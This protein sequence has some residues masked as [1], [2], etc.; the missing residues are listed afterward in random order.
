MGYLQLQMKTEAT[1]TMAVGPKGDVPPPIKKGKSFAMKDV[2]QNACMPI[3]YRQLTKS[4][5]KESGRL[6]VYQEGRTTDSAPFPG[7]PAA[8]Y[9]VPVCTAPFWGLC[10]GVRFPPCCRRLRWVESAGVGGWLSCLRGLRRAGYKRA[11]RVGRGLE[12]RE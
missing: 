7:T 1:N 6:R 8:E 12:A 11:S 9:I 10:L 3:Q 5:R 4:G 2:Y